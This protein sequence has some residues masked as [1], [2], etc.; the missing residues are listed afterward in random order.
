M[1][2]ASKR[3]DTSA[4]EE[5]HVIIREEIARCDERI[6]ERMKPVLMREFAKAKRT[7]RRLR[8]VAFINGQE[9]YAVEPK[10][11]REWLVKGDEL[12]ASVQGF[13]QACE[14]SYCDQVLYSSIDSNL[15]DVSKP[16]NGKDY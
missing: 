2:Q 7:Y 5:I 1:D 15:G 6:A 9:L 10:A 4:V 16:P 8:G 11:D 12:P 14:A 3:T 13:V